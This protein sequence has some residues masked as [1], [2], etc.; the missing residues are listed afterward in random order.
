MDQRLGDEVER[1]RGQ[2]RELQ[3]AREML[4]GITEGQRRVEATSEGLRSELAGL[5]TEMATGLGAGEVA[6]EAL[7]RESAEN[8]RQAVAE[9]TTCREHVAAQLSARVQGLEV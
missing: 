1:G 8:L 6:L 2:L 9:D 3:D 7:R 5:R 4:A